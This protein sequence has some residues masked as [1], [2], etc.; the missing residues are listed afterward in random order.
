MGKSISPA[1]NLAGI[2]AKVGCTKE[3]RDGSRCLGD[4]L[5]DDGDGGQAEGYFGI[6]RRALPL[7]SIPA[8]YS[9]RVREEWSC[10]GRPGRSCR[11]DLRRAE[12]IALRGCVKLANDSVRRLSRDI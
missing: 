5:A 2:Q 9:Y 3:T 8:L 6:C 10:D 12:A 11:R 1:S 7:E 4:A